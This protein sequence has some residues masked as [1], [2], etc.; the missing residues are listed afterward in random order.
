M[1]TRPAASG[2]DGT[3]RVAAP[4]GP[5][6]PRLRGVDVLRGLAVVGML[7]ADNRG[8]AAIPDQLEHAAWHGLRVADVVF[9]VF[10][11]VVGVSVPFSR[12]AGAPRAALTR[13]LRLAVLGWLVV[14]A[15]YGSATAGVG[16]LGH[17]AGAH[18]LCWLLLRLPRRAQVA[19]G[20]GVLAGL[21]ALGAVWGTGPDRSWGHVLDADQGASGGT[22]GQPGRTRP[23]AQQEPSSR[24]RG[25]V[26]DP[27]PGEGEARPGVPSQ[28]HLPGCRI[29]R[30]GAG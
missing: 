23:G 16:V 29:G 17:V 26:L 8:N 1:A 28:P 9:P 19:T 24:G 21:G 18:L 11:L 22:H 27:V 6:R 30:A 5:S 2:P 20:A 4:G 10:P 15:K 25:E 14:T 3:G 7:L 13:V 12:R